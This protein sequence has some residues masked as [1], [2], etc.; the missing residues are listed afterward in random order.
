V[1]LPNS[2][3]RNPLAVAKINCNMKHSI[4][5]IALIC[6]LNKVS[7]GQ[8]SANFFFREFNLSVNRTTVQNNNTEDRYGFGLGAY[9]S[10]MADKKLNIVFGM[11]YNRTSQF[12][13]AMYEGHFAQATDLSY[14]LNCFSVPVGFR[15]N[16][17]SKTKVFIET[18]GFADLVINS[19]RTGT[20]QTY[21]PDENGMIDNTETKFDE[22]AGLSNSFGFYF[23]LGVR[24]PI[25][26][27][28]LII[29]PDY[30]FGINKLYSYQDDILNRYFRINMGIKLN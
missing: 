3:S 11:E 6:F 5:L 7:Y 21:L 12:K 20:M 2:C 15:L 23:G 18:G 14:S 26:G 29:K 28:E 9:H 30:K 24:I 4:L 8:D 22:K 16:I 1:K 25:F 17:G 13:K 10:F 27:Y 19:N